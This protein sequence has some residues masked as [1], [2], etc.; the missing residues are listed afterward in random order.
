MRVAPLAGYLNK[1]PF[2]CHIAFPVPAG[3]PMTVKEMGWRRF[4]STGFV[5]DP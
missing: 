5:E 4:G 1:E 2:L 3:K